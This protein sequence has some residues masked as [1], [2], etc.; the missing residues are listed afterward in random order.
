MSNDS[1]SAPAASR[2]DQFVALSS[3]LTGFTQDTLAPPFDP[4]DPPLKQLYLSTCDKSSTDTVNQLLAAFANLSG[5]PA[6]TIA[7][8]LL[9]TGSA[10]PSQTA[11]MA[12]SINKLWYLGCW[13]EP[14]ST[15][16]TQYVVV[17]MNAYV[18]GLAW[19]AMQAH[20]MG[21]SELKFGYWNSRP[22][23]LTGTLDPRK[24]NHG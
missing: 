14:A 21:Y 2:L 1:P 8:T 12:R 13:Y 10:N 20:P 11:L 24:A 19:K 7:N 5:Q 17:A 22:P 4:T 3:V 23:V 15:N 9:E 6:Q 16:A 18:G